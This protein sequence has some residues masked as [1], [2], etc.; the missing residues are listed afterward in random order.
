MVLRDDKGPARQCPRPFFCQVEAAET[1]IWLTEVAPHGERAKR[2][3]GAPR[4]RKQR[5]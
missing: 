3:L 2:L 1:G 5:G 4:F